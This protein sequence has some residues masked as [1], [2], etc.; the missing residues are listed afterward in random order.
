MKS[1][2]KAFHSRIGAYIFF[3]LAASTY[4]FL[5]SA[6]WAYG[7]IADIYPL[8]ENFVPTLFGIIIACFIVTAGFLLALA[9]VGVFTPSAANLVS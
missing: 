8:G 3:A 6:S 1:I 9:A 4:T 7:W 2:G 5:H